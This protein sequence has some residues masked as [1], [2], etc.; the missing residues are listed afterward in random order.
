MIQ[1][2]Q[3]AWS[4]KPGTDGSVGGSQFTSKWRLV[5]QVEM[6]NK[7]NVQVVSSPVGEDSVVNDRKL[8]SHTEYFSP[9]PQL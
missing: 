8:S 7:N 5:S 1:T 9:H 3:G 6:N 4:C 2:S